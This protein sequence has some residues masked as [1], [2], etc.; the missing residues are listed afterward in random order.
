VVI[1]CL[2][3]MWRCGHHPGTGGEDGDR[4]QAGSRHLLPP[5]PKVLRRGMLS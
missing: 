2:A 4:R 5:G 3:A 1:S